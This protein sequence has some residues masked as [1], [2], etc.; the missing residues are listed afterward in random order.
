MDI[1]GVLFIAEEG[2]VFCP[3]HV[4]WEAKYTVTAPK[5]LFIK[6]EMD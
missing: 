2:G 4:V 1:E 3:G 5:P 6:E